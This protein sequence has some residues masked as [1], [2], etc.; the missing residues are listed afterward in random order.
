MENLVFIYLV[1]NFISMLPLVWAADKRTVSNLF[2]CVITL[3]FSPIIG[4]L[5]VLCYPLKEEI[6]YQEKM[7]IRMDKI[8]QKMNNE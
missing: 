7:I 6:D 1:V 4:F 3:L 2:A 5:F 8:L